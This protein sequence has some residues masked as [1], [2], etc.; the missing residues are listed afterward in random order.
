VFAEWIAYE[1][2]DLESGLCGCTSEGFDAW[3]SDPASVRPET[4][5]AV[6]RLGEGFR[7][8]E[9]LLRERVQVPSPPPKKSRR[10]AALGARSRAT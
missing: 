9:K 3:T 2:S 4:E 5:A 8:L 7:T 10:G 6:A 1:V